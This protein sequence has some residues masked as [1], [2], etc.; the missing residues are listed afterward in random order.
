MR[1][2]VWPRIGGDGNSSVFVGRVLRSPPRWRKAEYAAS[3]ARTEGGQVTLEAEL[4]VEKHTAGP[5]QENQK[6]AE[7]CAF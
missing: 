1:D 4:Y 7:S 2:V 6:L 5:W 3:P